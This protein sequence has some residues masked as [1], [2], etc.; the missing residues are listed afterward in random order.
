M[1]QTSILLKKSVYILTFLKLLV[2]FSCSSNEKPHSISQLLL[3][4]T[5]SCDSTY[6]INNSNTKITV[7]IRKGKVNYLKLNNNGDTL[8]IKRHLNISLYERIQFES[9]EPVSKR[10][11]VDFESLQY[12]LFYVNDSSSFFLETKKINN[13]KYFK[14]HFDNTEISTMDSI[15]VFQ[16]CDYYPFFGYLNEL[17]ISNT[18]YS[19]DEWIE[20]PN[21]VLSGDSVLPILLTYKPEEMPEELEEAEQAQRILYMD[22][23]IYKWLAE[24]KVND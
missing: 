21:S 12:T 23:Y 8:E 19:K 22:K 24:N 18:S 10:L 14:T 1:F 5:K 17:D 16:P 3:P 20:I 6:E 4:S 13:K 9:N 2:F 15:V 7:C 11:I